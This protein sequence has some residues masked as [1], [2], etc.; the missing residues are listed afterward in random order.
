MWSC[1]ASLGI[2]DAFDRDFC[3][4]CNKEF[5]ANPPDWIA[6]GRHL[7]TKHNFG[8]CSTNLEQDSS[9]DFG[10]H[11]RHIHHAQTDTFTSTVFPRNFFSGERTFG[12]FSEGSSQPASTYD[13]LPEEPAEVAAIFRAQVGLL[14]E[15][16]RQIRCS[17]K[18]STIF[19]QND[20][21]VNFQEDVLSRLQ[22]LQIS[23]ARTQEQLIL[24]G[25]SFDAL[26][27]SWDLCSCVRAQNLS[28]SF[29]PPSEI[30]RM[31]LIDDIAGKDSLKKWEYS[32]DQINRWLLHILRFS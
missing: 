29:N 27:I 25:H 12:V 14:F 2:E 5:Q 7:V 19:F 13:D 15:E 4:Y 20:E 31:Y 10:G 6:K 28:G 11:L 30:Y 23:A 17:D 24:D 18:N 26:N 1:D 22:D 3:G 21:F 9:L 8:R 16:F 32:R